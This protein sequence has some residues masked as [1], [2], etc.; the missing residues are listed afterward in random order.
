MSDKKM[1]ARLAKLLA[2]PETRSSLK[3]FAGSVLGKRKKR[4]KRKKNK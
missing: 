3:S 4:K 2:D 1:I